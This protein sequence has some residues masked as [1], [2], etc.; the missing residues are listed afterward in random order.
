MEPIERFSVWGSGAVLVGMMLLSLVALVTI[1]SGQSSESLLRDI[2]AADTL[3]ATIDDTKEI[4]SADGQP[5]IDRPQAVAAIEATPV[6]DQPPGSP[7]PTPR[8]PHTSVNQPLSPIRA[9]VPNETPLSPLPA[10]MPTTAPESSTPPAATPRAT[11]VPVPT[12]LPTPLDPCPQP[13]SGIQL[14]HNQ[15]RIE[16]G[17]LVSYEAGVLV[18]ATA[19]GPVSLVVTVETQVL[20]DLAAATQV[21]VEA[22]L[23]GNGK[24]K[25]K[26]VE[27]L[28]PQE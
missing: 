9:G 8:P 14:D 17:T 24:L 11:P 16:R 22:Q 18:L 5:P 3:T 6:P 23:T 7:S 28:C 12:P 19:D 21:R 27:V 4:D 20:G 13:E 10:A 25:G 26:R 15:V 1:W 2:P